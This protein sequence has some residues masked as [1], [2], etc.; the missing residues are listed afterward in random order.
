MFYHDALY[1]NN[2]T[3]AT[4]FGMDGFELACVAG[5]NAGNVVCVSTKSEYETLE[6]LVEASKNG[7]VTFA[8]NVGADDSCNG[9]NDEWQPVQIQPR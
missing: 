9:R 8:S 6:D 4:E 1:V 3:G 5:K 2:V 7:K